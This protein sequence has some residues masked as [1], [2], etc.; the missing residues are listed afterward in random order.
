[1]RCGSRPITVA[2]P[3]EEW[4]ERDRLAWL[5]AIA[6]GDDDLLA[7]DRPALRWKSELQGEVFVRYYGIWLAWLKSRG[8]LDPVHD[9]GGAGNKA[10][11]H[12]IPQ[13]PTRPWSRRKTSS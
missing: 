1:M 9:P 4:P 3:F 7:V 2:M 8:E 10:A 6:P 13:G 5:A 12:G 11:A